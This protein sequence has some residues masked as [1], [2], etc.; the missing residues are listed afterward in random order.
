MKK[1]MVLWTNR[2]GEPMQAGCITED[3]LRIALK[4]ARN[5]NPD[6]ILVLTMEEYRQHQQE[7]LDA[8]RAA[9]AS[10]RSERQPG[11]QRPRAAAHC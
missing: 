10:R 6:Q 8:Q 9:N 11:A 4:R 3:E 5:M 1:T 2:D 7:K